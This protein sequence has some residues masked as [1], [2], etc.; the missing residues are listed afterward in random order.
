MAETV[1]RQSA[2]VKRIIIMLV[3]LGVGVGVI[4]CLQIY[5][6]AE[7]TI[8]ALALAGDIVHGTP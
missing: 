8:E 4:L 3:L 5:L 1:S 7:L 2:M 6:I